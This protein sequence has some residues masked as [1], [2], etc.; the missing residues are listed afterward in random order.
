MLIQP[1]TFVRLIKGCPLDNSYKDTIYF[2]TPTE[3]YSYFRNTLTN[4][5][6]LN[7]QSYQRY[8]EGVI[9]VNVSA[10][11]LYGVNYMMFQNGSF[12]TKWFYAFVNEIEYV[13]N[14]VSRVY[15]EIDIMQTWMFDYRNNIK[16]CFIVRQHSETDNIGDN[17]IA[18]DVAY[19]DYKI[20]QTV[21]PLENEPRAVVL[22]YTGAIPDLDPLPD[23][24]TTADEG[25]YGGNY[26]GTRF[27][28]YRIE[29]E[30]DANNLNN[31]ISGI[32]FMTLGGFIAAFVYPWSIASQYAQ[33]TYQP[34]NIRTFVIRKPTTIDGY[35]PKN[36]KLFTFPY[37]CVNLTPNNDAGKD[38]AFEYFGNTTGDTSEVEFA[39]TAPLAPAANLISYP[40]LYNGAYYDTTCAVQSA[41]FPVCS[42]ASGK[43]ADWFANNSLSILAQSVGGIVASKAAGN[44]AQGMTVQELESELLKNRDIKARGPITSARAEAREVAR[45]TAKEQYRVSNVRA[46]L[47]AQKE[48]RTDVRAAINTC[49]LASSGNTSYSSAQTDAMFATQK[50]GFI[51][52]RV[53]TIRNHN[54]KIVDDYF[55][56]YG[57]AINAVKMPNFHA[58][59]KWTYIKTSGFSAYGNVP[60]GDMADIRALHDRGITY[61]DK[62]AVIGDY[63]VNN[64]I[65]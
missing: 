12:G 34:Q 7:K 37:C 52:A 47:N 53:K 18:E 38:F 9:T 49:L 33:S 29:S 6:P 30:E 20:G 3:Q 58:R 51:S 24:G 42:I 2:E 54:A 14:T 17:L 60:S 48:A 4:G 1:N 44:S 8:A 64:N 59:A 61:W 65:L 19:G 39:L 36:K 46:T 13:G 28:I 5:I 16:P 35:T 23:I 55:T 45:E 15:Y 31:L 63:S 27:A 32:D 56:M 26:Q 11:D 50:G 25:F 22:Q 10:D 62:D 21:T 41:T 57:Y 40:V 43:L